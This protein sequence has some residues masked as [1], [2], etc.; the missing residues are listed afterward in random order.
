MTLAEALETSQEHHE[1]AVALR[2]AFDEAACGDR[3]QVTT[4]TLAWW[5]RKVEGHIVR[6][7]KFILTGETHSGVLR[8]QLVAVNDTDPGHQGHPAYKSTGPP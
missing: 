3:G 7:R 4:R 6:G 5:C 8:W 1:K 2:H